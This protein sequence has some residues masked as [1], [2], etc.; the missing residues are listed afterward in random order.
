M[1]D[2]NSNAGILAF[3]RQALSSHDEDYTKGPI[4]RALALLAI[5]MMLEMTMES[6]FAI[7]DIFFVARLGADAVTAVGLTEAVVTVIYAIAIG[8]STSA[9]AMVSR[10][11]GAGKPEDAAVVGGQAIWVG[12]AVALLTSFLGIRFAEDILSLMGAS[13]GVIEQG[14]GYT[15]IL[16]GGSITILFLFLLN[17]VLR[18]AGDASYAMKALWLANGINIVLDPCLIY[19]WGP[20]PEMGVTGAATATTIGRGIGVVYQLWILFGAGCRVPMQLSHLRLSPPV[21]SRLLR[22]SIGGVI[23]HTISTSSW[24]V[25]IRI[26]SNYGSSA[27]AGY[28][29]ALRMFEFSFLPAWGLGNAAATLV[30]QN[31][32][33]GNPERAERSV[34][35][36]AQYNAVFLG[37]VSVLFIAFAEQLVGLFMD[38][39]EVIYFGADALRFLSYGFVFFAIGMVL[40]QGLNG[41]GDTDTPMLLNFFAYWIVQ[42]PLAYFLAESAGFGPRGAWLAVL[43]AETLLALTAVIAFRTGRW[44][45]RQV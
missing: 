11:I 21:L 2:H 6:I 36:A 39:P 24:I 12:M 35:K 25:L 44:K 10:R 3:L 23:Q 45:L 37:I 33:A 18:G 16:L 15:T 20:F 27:V 19:G 28:T 8:L 42:I 43:V 29:I 31:L 41:A 7:V 34:W 26:V 1:T 30:G 9:T 40:V 14:T 22:I 38:D 13:A 17:A 32:G 5:P 4:R